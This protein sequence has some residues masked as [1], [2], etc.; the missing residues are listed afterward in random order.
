MDELR[1]QQLKELEVF[2][3]FRRVCEQYHLRYFAIAGTCLGAVRHRGFIPW[4]DDMD[5]AMPYEDYETFC[6]VAASALP[7]PYALYG[8][9]NPHWHGTYVKV[10]DESTT[11][12][13]DDPVGCP[14]L[15][16]GVF[17]D[18]MPMFGLRGSKRYLQRQARWCDLLR[19]MNTLQRRPYQEDWRYL[20]RLFWK[21]NQRLGQGRDR[22]YYLNR[23][24][25]RFDQCPLSEADVILFSYRSAFKYKWRRNESTPSILDADVFAESVLL[26][27][28][29]TTV[30]VPGNYDRYLQMEFGDYMTLP[31]V[32]KR[33]SN[34]NYYLRDLDRSYK[35]YRDERFCK[36]G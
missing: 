1:Q 11:F 28:E 2:K 36:L 33:V 4:D 25:E 23:I 34:H 14:D 15:Y 24:A 20:K 29:D 21:I 5:V 22:D 7:Q 30:D 9:E 16:R 13:E 10:I 3:A 31:P 19:F 35:E 32:E 6:R 27:F 26:P 18:V 12:L 17:L 8:Q